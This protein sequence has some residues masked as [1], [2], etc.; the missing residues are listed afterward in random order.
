MLYEVITNTVV[1][2]EHDR[3]MI[4]AADHII[5]L[6]PQ[7]GE[8]GGEVVCAAPTGEFFH[9]RCALTARYLRGSYNFV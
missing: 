3:R 9:D 4:E 1:V 7:S 2:V 6:G 5:E 8:K